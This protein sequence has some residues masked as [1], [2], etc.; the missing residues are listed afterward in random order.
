M[1]LIVVGANRFNG[2]GVV[3]RDCAKLTFSPLTSYSIH[4][5]NLYFVQNSQ[6]E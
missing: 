6:K 5:P 1:K 3:I 4:D 2:I